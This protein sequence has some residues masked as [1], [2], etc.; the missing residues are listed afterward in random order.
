MLGASGVVGQIAVQSARLLGA[1]RV[2]AG[3]RAADGLDRAKALGADAVVN[4]AA[5]DDDLVEAL[6]EASGGDGF[7]LVLDPVWGDPASAAL[8]ACRRFGRLV[9]IG[10]SAGPY[11]TL[12]SATVRTCTSR[13]SAGSRTSTRSGA[14]T[15]G[16]P[17][18]TAGPGTPGCSARSRPARDALRAGRRRRSS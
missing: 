8:E 16:A 17:S 6:R 12:A 15:C 1:G 10:E 5:A 13:G 14:S 18:G 4:L 11:V 9:Q 3:A 2:V 7:D